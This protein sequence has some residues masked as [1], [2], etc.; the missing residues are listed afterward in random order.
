[1]SP[2]ARWPLDLVTKPSDAPSA[3]DS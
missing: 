3:A 2:R 1:V